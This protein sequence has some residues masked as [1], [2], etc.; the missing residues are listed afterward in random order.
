MKSKAKKRPVSVTIL[1]GVYL[2][3]GAAGFVFHFKEMF[4]RQPDAV[5]VEFVEIIAVV[6]GL[7]M[8][9]G[10]NWARWLALAWIAFHVVLSAFHPLRELLVHSIFFIVIAWILFRADARQYFRGGGPPDAAGVEP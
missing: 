7:F 9:R 1:C 10:Q 4:A 2:L 5:T 3:V 6:S 8:L